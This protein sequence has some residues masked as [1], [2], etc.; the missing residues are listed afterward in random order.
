MAQPK[1]EVIE[2]TDSPTD[3]SSRDQTTQPEDHGA[4]FSALMLALKALSQRAFIA[5]LDCFCLL[6]VG[7]AFWLCLTIHDPNVTQLVQIGGYF[8]FVLAA[9]LIVRRK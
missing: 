8:A 5:L 3:T 9:N 7:S 4:A 6:T 1:W 2:S